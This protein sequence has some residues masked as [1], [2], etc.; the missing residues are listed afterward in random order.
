MKFLLSFTTAVLS[1][2]FVLSSPL[3]FKRLNDSSSRETINFDFAWRFQLGDEGSIVQC[4]ESSFPRNLST[5]QCHGLKSNTATNADDCRGVCCADIMCAIWQFGKEGCWIGQSN[6]RNNPSKAWIGGERDIPAKPPSPT[7]NGPSSRN[8]DDSGWEVVDTPHDGLITGKYTQDGPE[9]QAYLPKNVTWYRKHFNLPIEWKGKSIWIYFE[10]VFRAATIYLNGE[11]ILY[12]DSGYTSFV[13]PLNNATNVFYGNGKANENVVAVRASSDGG[14]GWWYEGGGIYRHVYLISTSGSARA[15]FVPDGVYGASIITGPIHAHDP[16]DNSKG[17]YADSVMFRII[18]EVIHEVN[19]EEKVY[20][21]SSLFDESGKKVGSSYTPPNTMGGGTITTISSFNLSN[22][23]LW[24]PT[25]PYLYTLKCDLFDGLYIDTVNVTIGV[26]S[27]NWDANTGFYLNG[28]HFTWRGFN[29]HND[30]TGV[31]MAVPD[32][33]NLFRGQVMRA[34]GA[35]SWRMSHN[36]PTPIML[37]ILDSLGII[38]WD[39]NRE[40]GNNPI[41]VQNQKDMVRRDRNHPSVM[42]WSFCN[43]GGCNHQN[44]DEMIGKQFRN[45]SYE[46]DPYR[47]VTANMNGDIGGGL[48][49]VIDI[50]GFSHRHGKDFDSFHEKFPSKPLIGSEC[51]S[52]VTQ[53]GEDFPSKTVLGNFNGNCNSEQTEYQLNRGYVAGCMVWTLFDYYGEPHPVGWPHVSSSFGSIDLAGFAKASAYWYRSWWLYN[54]M[55]NHSTGGIDV[56][57]NPPKLVNPSSAPQEDNAKD[58]YLVHIVENWESNDHANSR[59]I[60]VYTNAPMVELF[61]NDKSQGVQQL[62][63]QGWAEWNVTYT[64]GNLTATAL[65]SQHSIV[66]THTIITS[67]APSRIVAYVDVPCKDTGTGTS[68]IL[69]GQDAGMVSAAILDTNGHVVP[70]ASH[71][72]TFNI[73]SGPGRIIGVGNGDPACHEPNQASWRSAYHGLVRVI[74]Q[75]TEDHAS[76]PEHRYRL[77]QIDRDGGTRTHIQDPGIPSPS[78]ADGIVVKVSA[79]G[80]GSSTVTIPVSTDSVTHNVLNVAKQ[81]LNMT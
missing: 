55:K 19:E 59:I 32:R 45:V 42:A 74:I 62:V 67:S 70:S 79:S 24:S 38:V 43:E 31:G 8:F 58:G 75:V 14:S 46:E 12:H 27:T 63:W 1:I 10:G 76:S 7:T 47:P 17:M 6:D 68:L 64:P 34:V 9:K 73:V 66:A 40:F 41:W 20:V 35:N 65:S 60:H 61:I 25:R 26:R 33:I 49:M 5:V 81:S 16:N 52:C 71:N 13:V 69:N 44:Q 77:I 28:V 29:N 78:F 39:E 48:S 3:L 72:V 50:Q 2:T 51:C 56:P 18:A 53:R 30:F 11:M 21:E 22:V 80:L 36:P 37:D 23:E 4:P 15:H 54:A 57:I